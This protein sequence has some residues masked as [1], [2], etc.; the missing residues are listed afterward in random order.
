M[1]IK[2]K[3]F[4]LLLFVVLLVSCTTLEVGVETTPVITP[5]DP[6]AIETAIA[7]SV[8]ATVQAGETAAT[9][10]AIPVTEP[11]TANEQT[12]P[13][14]EPTATLV[15]LAPPSETA[16]LSGLIYR[17]GDQLFQVG[18]DQQPIALA[19]GLDPQ[20]LPDLF[21]PRA[22]VSADGKQM[23][24]WW[25][26]SDLWL[27]DLTSGETRNL[28][29]TPESE[30]CCAQFWPGRPDTIIFLTRLANGDEMSFKMA[31]I[32]LD[33]SNYRLLDDSATLLGLPAL[34]PDGNTIAYDPDG[35]PALYRFESGPEVFNPA[36]Y[37]LQVSPK[38]EYGLTNPS[39]SPTGKNIAWMVSGDPFGSGMPQ[40]G[41]MVFDLEGKTNRLLHPYEPAGTGGGF[42]PSVWSPDGNWLV[43]F[44]QSLNE[45]GVWVMH[46]DGS[47]EMLVYAPSTVRSVLGLQALWSPDSQQLLVSDP[48]AEGGIRLTLL[49]LL[50]SQIETASLPTG[51]I[52]VAWVK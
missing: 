47:G 35:K 44:D 46:L 48:N 4:S 14:S 13:T 9:E 26:W 52:P 49:N 50:T 37:N 38:L 41:A 16:G 39:W 20:V 1:F 8:Q 25:D 10:T 2:G 22:A 24:S 3:F 5:V 18:A 45:P 19:P 7:K 51:A 33:G 6:A 43:V 34:S 17:L 28:T 42:L 23:L 31:A 27:V 36:D 32:N 12:P 11:T 40:G 15:E 30:E 29:N 21:T